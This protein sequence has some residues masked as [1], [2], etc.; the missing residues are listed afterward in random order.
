MKVRGFRIELEGVESELEKLGLVEYVV[1]GVRRAHSNQDELVAGLLG[2]PA[3]FD[4]ESFLR[5]A[6][7]VLPSYAVPNHLV[8]IATPA[9]TGSGKLDRRS[10][11][12]DAIAAFER[13]LNERES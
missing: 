6:A 3:D 2:T 10:L 11:R 5:S 13:M 9:F 12:Q 8:P 7:S 1:V 4:E